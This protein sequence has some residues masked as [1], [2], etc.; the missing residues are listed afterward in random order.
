VIDLDFVWTPVD[1]PI[2]LAGAEGKSYGGLTLRFAPNTN[3]VITT[4]LG[5]GKEDLP[6]TRLPWADL[7]GQFSGPAQPSGAA[8]FIPK[9]HPDFPPMW[10]TRHYGVL[11]L[12][13][14]G[15]DAQTF[16]P[17]KEIRCQYRV[18]IHR[19]PADAKRLANA[20]DV[21]VKKPL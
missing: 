20:Y 2:T 18:W 7:S 9:S 13:W 4:P 15:I 5:D 21:Y 8:I 12:G 6:M 3:T 11:C 10:L 17:G 16:P 14:P 19:G 1:N